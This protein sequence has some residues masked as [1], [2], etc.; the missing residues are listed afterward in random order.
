MRDAP[1]TTKS[2]QTQELAI[3]WVHEAK[4]SKIIKMPSLQS[5]QL[6]Y[7]LLRLL[8]TVA[9]HRYIQLEVKSPYVPEMQ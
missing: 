3:K 8:A 6:A 7:T 5:I 4:R 9:K 1:C 2:P